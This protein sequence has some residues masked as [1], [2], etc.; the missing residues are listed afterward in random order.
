MQVIQTSVLLKYRELFSFLQNH[1]PE[2][3]HEVQRSY[4]SAARVY[5]E[6]GFRRYVRS[7]GWIRTRTVE[8]FENLVVEREGEPSVDPAR[9]QYAKLEGPSVTLAYM[10]DDKNHVCPVQDPIASVASLYVAQ[11]E[12]V[13][14]LFRALLLVLM[15]NATAEYIFVTT[16]FQTSPERRI[17]VRNDSIPSLP[18]QDSAFERRSQ[19]GSENDGGQPTIADTISSANIAAAKSDQSTLDAVWQQI[20]DPV[21]DYCQVGV[22][23]LDLHSNSAVTTS[24]HRPL[25]VL[26]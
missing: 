2:V 21:L 8:K 4:I 25:R 16:F 10:A 20:M 13:E 12:N 26:S 17:K 14:A 5:Y 3:A 1:A 18:A 24:F 9:L 19:N 7:L 23:H 22:L 11:K 6:T 15:D